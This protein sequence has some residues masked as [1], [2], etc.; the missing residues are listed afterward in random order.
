MDLA[1][2]GGRGNAGGSRVSLEWLRHM[3]VLTLPYGK[4]DCAGICLLQS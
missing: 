3:A 2:V 1:M 4:T